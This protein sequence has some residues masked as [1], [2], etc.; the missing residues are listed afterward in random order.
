MRIELN[1]KY[2]TNWGESLVVCIAGKRF[3]MN[4]SEDGLWSLV[5]EDLNSEDLSD[6]HYEVEKDGL[7]VKKEWRS[8]RVPSVKASAKAISVN[9]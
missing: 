3:P 6:Y 7:T 4:W 1:V 5:L 8:H 2:W 9:D